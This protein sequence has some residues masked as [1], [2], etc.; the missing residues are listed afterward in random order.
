M[1]KVI[2]HNMTYTKEQIKN[3]YKKLSPEMQSFIMD[4]EN[5]EFIENALKKSGLNDDQSNLADS[6]ILYSMYGLQSFSDAMNNIS[7]ISNKNI[8]ELSQLKDDLE[9]NIFKK[10]PSALVPEKINLNKSNENR[11]D[12]ISVKY[13]LNAD[14]KTNLYK[15]LQ[16]LVI[17]DGK[18]KENLEKITSN[19]SVSQLLAEQI[20]EDLKKKTAKTNV[21]RPPQPQVSP[22]KTSVPEIK[23]QNLPAQPVTQVTNETPQTMPKPIVPTPPKPTPPPVQNPQPKVEIKTEAPKPQTSEPPKAP[24]KYNVDPYREPLN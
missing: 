10:I 6:E 1:V 8:I 13:S 7:K 12:E 18:E 2:S 4:P 3:S 23:P 5:S 9:E 24:E 19:L 21:T 20:Y 11:L 15:L 16:N 14:Q 22:I 17:E